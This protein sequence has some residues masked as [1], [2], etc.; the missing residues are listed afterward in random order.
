MSG[1]M[2]IYGPWDSELAELMED[3]APNEPEERQE[4]EKRING[5]S[6][7]LRMQMHEILDQYVC[8]GNDTKQLLDGEGLGWSL[9]RYLLTTQEICRAYLDGDIP[10]GFMIAYFSNEI[11]INPHGNWL[12]T[13]LIGQKQ[14]I[15]L[16]IIEAQGKM[17][18]YLRQA[19]EDERL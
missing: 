19:R 9:E 5:Y 11:P 6:N 10:D 2:R 7:R 14:T 4:L 17:A 1:Y 16:E 8:N 13:L 3:D 15:P 18:A 12:L